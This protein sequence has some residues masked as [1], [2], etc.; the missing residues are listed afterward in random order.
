MDDM[1][2]IEFATWA[3]SQADLNSH[4][5][6]RIEIPEPARPL[7]AYM[8]S[9]DVPKY[10]QPMRVAVFQSVKFTDGVTVTRCW[11]LVEIRQ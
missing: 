4:D 5:L 3:K 1:N 7:A 6:R 8:P 9:S 2:D 11:Q 10:P